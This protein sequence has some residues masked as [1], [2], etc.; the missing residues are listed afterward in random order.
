[1]GTTS[2]GNGRGHRRKGNGI[3]GKKRREGNDHPHL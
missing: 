1:M 3:D 2:K